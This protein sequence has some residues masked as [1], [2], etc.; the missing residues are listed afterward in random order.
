MFT[1]IICM[2]EQWWMKNTLK[3][4]CARQSRYMYKE[5]IEILKIIER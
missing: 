3:Y 2:Y 4:V 1:T 5:N